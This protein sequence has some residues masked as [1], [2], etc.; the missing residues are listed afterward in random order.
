MRRAPKF[1]RGHTHRYWAEVLGAQEMHPGGLY[2]PD[3]TPGPGGHEA[4]PG[5]GGQKSPKQGPQ[6]ESVQDQHC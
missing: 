4:V 5:G 1:S 2:P 6:G 3:G